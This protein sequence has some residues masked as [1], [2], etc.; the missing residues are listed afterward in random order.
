VIEE[1]P[2]LLRLQEVD[3]RIR[4][5]REE[6]ATFDPERE[7]ARASAASEQAAVEAASQ[8]HTERE[9]EHRRL[10]SELEDEERL[11]EKLD[12][13]VY[14][15][16]SKQAMDAIQSQIQAAKA[17]KSD[18]EDEI[19]EILDQVESAL[20]TRE[21]AVAFEQ[22]QIAER[23]RLEDARA[24]RELALADEAE[25]LT[26]ERAKR[27]A[28][29]EAEPLRRYEDARRKAWP[30][31]ALAVTKFCPACRIVIP[32]QR[33]N[34]LGLAKKFVSCGSCHRILYRESS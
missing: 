14:E 22:D 5:T 1:I 30:V 25:R 4:A 32:P 8:A 10:E 15:V 17:R 6:A 18:L 2:K 7:E 11:V 26:E 27:C 3:R 23:L 13:Q 33:W 19:L 28:E 34:E 9:Q 24:S 31:V 16:T 20:S 21:A 29:V 12:A